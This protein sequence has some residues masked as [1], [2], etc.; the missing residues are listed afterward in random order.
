M[1]RHRL[2]LTPGNVPILSEKQGN[3][4]FID[5]NLNY[6][7]VQKNHFG[8]IRFCLTAVS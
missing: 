6:M 8:N 2:D 1:D 5:K 7:P 3:E 4:P